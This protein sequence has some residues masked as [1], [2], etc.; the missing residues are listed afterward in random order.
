MFPFIEKDV[1]SA[2]VICKYKDCHHLGTIRGAYLYYADPDE[3][4]DIRDALWKKREGEDHIEEPPV[5][6]FRQMFHSK[7]V[8]RDEQIRNLEKRLSVLEAEAKQSL[9]KKEKEDL[10]NALR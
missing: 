4:C 2:V 10:K 9:S 7:D 5:S 1:D 3:R 8:N 6:L